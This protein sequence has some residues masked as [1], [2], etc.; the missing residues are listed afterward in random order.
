MYKYWVSGKICYELKDFKVGDKVK[1]NKDNDYHVIGM[2][3]TPKHLCLAD[4]LIVSK[5]GRTKIGVSHIGDEK[6]Y[7]VHPL[8]IKPIKE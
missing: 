3:N 7:M 4:C 6:I 2:V 8:I 5:I 1:W